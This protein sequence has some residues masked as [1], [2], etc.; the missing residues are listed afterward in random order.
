MLLGIVGID[1]HAKMASI[2]DVIIIKFQLQYILKKHSETAY[3]LFLVMHNF[4]EVLSKMVLSK[5][6]SVNPKPT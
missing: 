2:I 4:A 3:A 1:F 6:Q 5:K